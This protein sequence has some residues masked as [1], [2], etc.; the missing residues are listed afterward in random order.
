MKKIVFVLLIVVVMVENAKSQEKRDSL[1]IKTETIY[2]I[3]HQEGY[4]YTGKIIS[5]D[6]REIILE[7]KENGK[8]AIPKYMI[9][10][11]KEL[12]PEEVNEKG[13]Y[14]PSE[15]FS[16]R[17]FI[18]TNGLPIEKGES[19][20][21]W[22]LYGPD[23]QFGIGKNT[24]VGI[25]T[26]WIGMPVIGTFKYSISLGKKIN[27]GLGTLL[28][29]G[30]WALPDYGIALPFSALTLGDRRT[31]V[32]LSMGYGA[33]IAEGKTDGRFLLSGAALAKIGKKV[34]LVFDSFIMTDGGYKTV[35]DENTDPNTGIVTSISR[36]EKRAGFALLIPGVRWQLETNKA[37]QFGFAGLLVKNEF[38]P[39]PIPMIQWYRKL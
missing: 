2:L 37:F 17:Y 13:E 36:Q 33:V 39:V 25:M 24:G 14:I 1:K 5:Q 3:I 12:K 27:F 15:V 30:S 16:T 10:S 28:G 4:N 29:T 19:Y 34:S 32:T 38:L 22:N 31:N 35:N 9:K 7:T 21:Q 8:L 26:S 6:E 23:F 20:I 11:I 18:T